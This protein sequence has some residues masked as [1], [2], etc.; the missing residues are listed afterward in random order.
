LEE[1]EK[2]R[3]KKKA[4]LQLLLYFGG[5][6]GIEETPIFFLF[7]FLFCL[8]LGTFFF[9]YSLADIEFKLNSNS[10]KKKKSMCEEKDLFF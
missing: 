4:T 2:K 1:K 3:R 7:H 9:I 8:F 10:R 6:L 5:C